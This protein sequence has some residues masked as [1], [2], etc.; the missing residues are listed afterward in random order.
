MNQQIF[1][2]M[3]RFRQKVIRL[4]IFENKSVYETAIACGCS[5]EKVKR[6]MKK[7]KALTKESK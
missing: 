1:E 5:A 2:Q 6:V 4:A 3:G 7:W